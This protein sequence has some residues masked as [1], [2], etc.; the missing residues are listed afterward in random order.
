MKRTLTGWLLLGPI[1]LVPSLSLAAEQQDGGETPHDFAYGVELRTSSNQPFFRIDIPDTLYKESAWPDLRDVRVFNN[2]G[3]AVPFSLVEDFTVQNTSRSYLLRVFPIDGF[4]PVKQDNERLSFTSNNG[5][6]ISVPV[7]DVQQARQTFLLEVP[8]TEEPL[9]H[10]NQIKLNWQQLPEN[11]Q[12]SASVFYSN[13][14]KNWLPGV[15]KAPLMDLVSGNQRLLLDNINLD[16]ENNGRRFRYLLLVLDGAQ[17]S[18]LIKLESA[19]GSMD[20]RYVEQHT[21]SYSP[22][23]KALSGNEAEYS[24]PVPQLLTSITI[25]PA[26]NNTIL[27]LEIEYRSRADAPWQPLTQQVV[28]SVDGRTADPISVNGLQVQ[29]LRLKGINQQWGN[30][31]PIV[32]AERRGQTLFFNA[33]GS[34]PFLLAWGNKA[35]G[36]QAIA[37]NSLIPSSLRTSIATDSLPYATFGE[38]IELGGEARL[39][40]VSAV[41]KASLWKKSLLWVALII[42]AGALVLLTFKI[43]KDVQKKP[44]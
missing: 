37:I 11:W 38:K 42:G 2:Q 41:E 28:Y 20:E 29:S 40:A 25:R 27:P 36:P 26:Q 18:P 13:N 35:A 8:T 7:K 44:E 30:A 6:E 14:L 43:W 3:Q 19:E 4:T 24:W 23:G 5:I 17:N 21:I 22:T 31:M 32:N 39:T 10:L 1:W 12:T 9:P 33:Q 34:S 15:E 16:S